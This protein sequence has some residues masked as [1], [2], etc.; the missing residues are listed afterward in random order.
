MPRAGGG[1]RGRYRDHCQ[2]SFLIGLWVSV[3]RSHE[4]VLEAETGVKPAR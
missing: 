3:S 2:G 4:S 1:G